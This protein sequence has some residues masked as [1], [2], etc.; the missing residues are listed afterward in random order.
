MD[1]KNNLLYIRN[2]IE[3]ACKSCGRDSKEITLVGVSKTK[4]ASLVNSAIDAGLEDIGENYVQEITEKK[5]FLKK[6]NIHFIGHLQSNKARFIVPFA[7]LIH[8]VDSLSL[9]KEID[10]QAEKNNKVQ[11][12]LIE[13]NVGEEESKFGIKSDDIT[14]FLDQTQNFGNIKIKGI[15]GMAPLSEDP[16]PYFAKLKKIY[17][18]LPKDMRVYLSMGMSGDFREAITEG[19]NMV[20]IGSAIFGQ[21]NYNL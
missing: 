17:D 12:V 5:P 6:A 20:R 13:I 1:I 7:H 3:N 2:E 18:S 19:S 16:R 21:R 14:E 11:D 8:S 15:M 10:R 9:L 4:P